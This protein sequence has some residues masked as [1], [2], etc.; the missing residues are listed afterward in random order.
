[1]S[2]KAQQNN[3]PFQTTDDRLQEDDGET[4]SEDED[5]ADMLFDDDDDEDM[6]QE[7][8]DDGGIPRE[9]EEE[10]DD[11]DDDDEEMMLQEYDIE[12]IEVYVPLDRVPLANPANENNNDDVII[13]RKRKSR[14]LLPTPSPPATQLDKSVSQLSISQINPKKK[15]TTTTTTDNQSNNENVEASDN[16]TE[17]YKSCFLKVS[18]RTFKQM[19][20]NAIQDGNKLVQC[21]DTP[22]K[23]YTIRQITELTDQLHFKQLQQALWQEYHSISLKY[24]FSELKVTKQYAAKHNTCRIHKPSKSAIEKRQETIKRQRERI[25]TELNTHSLQLPVSITEWQPSIDFQILSNA[26]N[27]CV[28]KIQQKLKQEFQY[29]HELL[30]LTCADHHLIKKFYNLKPNE[31]Q[32]ELAKKIW[33]STADE[34]RAKEQQEILRQHIYLKRLPSKTDKIVNQL[35]DDNQIT[36]SNPFL[37]PD[38]RASFASRCSKIIIQCKFN[39]MTQ[40]LDE[41]ESVVRR[42]SLTL[43]DLQNRLFQLNKEDPQLYTNVLI[44]A[45]EQRRKA[46]I[47]RFFHTHLTLEQILILINGLKYIIPCQSLFSRQ[48]INELAKTDY[49]K[50]STK[51]KTCL[52]KNRMSI[53]D[54]RANKAFPELEKIIYDVYSKPLSRRL[55]RRAQREHRRVTSLQRLLRQRPDIM[56]CRVDKSPG[57]YIGNAAIIT[58]KVHEYMNNTAAYEEIIDGH[59]PLADNLRAVQNLLNYLVTQK[60][61]TKAQS[62]KLLP[63]L[64]KLELAH[65]HA[66]TKVHKPDIPIRPILAGINCPTALLSKFLNNLLAPIYLKVTAELTFTNSVQLVQSLE[67][68][69]SKGFFK[70]TT[71]FITADVKNLYTVIPREGGRQALIRFLEQYSNQGKIGTLSI[72]H[73]WKMARLILDNNTFAYN[74]KYYKQIRGGA[75]GSAFTQVY[76]NIYM[77][78]WE[79]DLIIHQQ[80]HNEI[81]GR[82]IDDIFMTTNQTIDE[83][84]IE[85]GKAQV[86]DINIEIEP[87]IATS[88][89]Y[90]DLTITNEN[91]QLR[92]TIYHKPTAE[93]YYLP[94]TSDH[95]HRYHRNVPYSALLRAAR[96]C[97]NVHDFN[98]ERQRIDISLLLSDYPPKLISNQFQRFF[99]VNK[100]ETLLKYLNERDYQQ[101]HHKLLHHTTRKQAEKRNISIEDLVKKPPVLQPKIYDNKL[102][103]PHY[104]FESGHRLQFSSQFQSWWKKYYQYPES[105]VKNINMRLCADK[106]RTLENLLIHKKPPAA[107]LKRMEPTNS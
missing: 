72:D 21:L 55:R 29:K 95:P 50:I 36:L 104:T 27:E 88:V 75:M 34:L 39:L 32:I 97:S 71:C 79:Q 59:C 70:S 99:Q 98:R 54:E 41:L 30:E 25:A 12:N 17:K 93:P 4:T 47:T 1:M 53:S 65:L 66:L 83:I 5:D 61:I 13:V 87:T 45:I 63:S 40:Q 2:D 103:Y 43:I 18:D 49:N 105:P 56:I 10:D 42:H 107:I 7:D 62:D 19:L 80:Q 90:L 26:I 44:A 74:G 46:M 89:N 76:A 106:N 100:A 38:Q 64:D 92:T 52:G 20:S 81:Y 84:N 16:D 101:L 14:V 94:Y 15:K 33:Q 77:L 11:D 57:F 69:V 67:K 37:D 8:L 58:G 31:E 60:A 73:I 82:Y 85:L 96:L 86:K 3:K 102:W 23:I 68:Y 78:E 35:V 6:A 24:D 22:E 28:E 91:G 9:E 51:I 48:T